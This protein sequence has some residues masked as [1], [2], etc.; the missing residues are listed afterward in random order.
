VSAGHAAATLHAPQSAV[1]ARYRAAAYISRMAYELARLLAKSHVRASDEERE[2]TCTAL[3][4]HYA[5]GRITSAELE[6]RVGRA[7]GATTAATYTRWWSTCRP[8]AAAAW[9]AA[10][11]APTARRCARTRPR[12]RR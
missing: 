4:E 5:A 1:N 7:Y 11:A 12:T 2:G 3:R 9:P 6:E 10:C 8:T